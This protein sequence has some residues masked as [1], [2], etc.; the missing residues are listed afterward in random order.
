MAFYNFKINYPRRHSSGYD[1]ESS[2]ED[3][4]ESSVEARYESFREDGNNIPVK[5]EQE[6]SASL[7][8]G[9]EIYAP[10]ALFPSTDSDKRRRDRCRE[11]LKVYLR[12]RLASQR[13]ALCNQIQQKLP[14]E[15]R[16]IIYG[17][18][19]EP[20]IQHVGPSMFT[21]PKKKKKPRGTRPFFEL[22]DEQDCMEREQRV[23]HLDH[24]SDIKFTNTATRRELAM[25][26]YRITSFSFGSSISAFD[27]S[28]TLKQCLDAFLFRTVDPWHIGSSSFDL[29]RHIQLKYDYRIL[30][31]SN[32]PLALFHDSKPLLCLP[33]G[34][35]CQLAC[36]ALMVPLSVRDFRTGKRNTQIIVGVQ[37]APEERNDRFNRCP[38]AWRESDGA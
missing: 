36:D 15:L 17:Y 3:G 29:I 31:Q 1:Y 6:H 22:L 23:H 14:R 10:R 2:I 7:D 12:S 11:A 37:Y 34:V 8:S 25:V 9:K 13:L 35:H 27:S 38:R 21:S 26:Y 28:V 24:L 5:G 18:I 20:R 32:R 4:Y 19:L 30:A 16:D 33:V